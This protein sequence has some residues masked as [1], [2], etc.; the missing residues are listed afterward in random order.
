M[1]LLSPNLSAFL[2]ISR[3]QTVHGA[4]RELGLTQTRMAEDLGVS[5]SYLNHLE[6]NQRPVTAQVLLRLAGLAAVPVLTEMRARMDA[7]RERELSEA[8]RRLEH[9]PPNERAVVEEF[10]RS[11]MNKFLHEPTVRLRAAASNGRGIGVVDTV[12]YLFGLERSGGARGERGAPSD[13]ASEPRE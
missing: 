6:R 4:A 2:A 3:A 9:L 1:S 11:L 8:L 7:V 10:S 12:R 5:P 13:P